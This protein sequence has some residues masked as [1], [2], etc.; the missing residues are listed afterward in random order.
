M[1]QRSNGF[2][3]GR[4]S[5]IGP[6]KK[7]DDNILF[8]FKEAVKAKLLCF[9]KDEDYARLV[10]TKN[11]EVVVIVGTSLAAHPTRDLT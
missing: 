3:D 1:K 5:L 6:C 7:Y 8:S 4:I 11:N 10:E 9:E 2:S